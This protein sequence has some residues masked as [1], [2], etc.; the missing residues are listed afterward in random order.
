[1]SEP[2]CKRQFRL[3][4][5]RYENEAREGMMKKRL[6]MRVVEKGLISLKELRQARQRQRMFGGRIGSNLVAL[7]LLSQQDLATFF[8]FFPREP[9]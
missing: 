2:L 9:E 8:S 4:R 3:C 5:H 1:M 7:D 6:G